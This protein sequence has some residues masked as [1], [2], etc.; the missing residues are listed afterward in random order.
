MR[1]NALAPTITGNSSTG[2]ACDL[3]TDA[4]VWCWGTN[5]YGQLGDGTGGRLT[6][7]SLGDIRI[8]VP[9]VE[10]A[11]WH[12]H[13]SSCLAHG[14]TITENYGLFALAQPMLG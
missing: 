4:T 3:R 5:S 6:D 12:T 9:I 11:F 13:A 10:S 14:R 2:Y 1:F 7:R 8:I